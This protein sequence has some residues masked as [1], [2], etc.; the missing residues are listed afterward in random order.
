LQELQ[1]LNNDLQSFMKSKSITGNIN[2]IG[3]LH[4]MIQDYLILRVSGLFDEKSYAIS[5]ERFFKDQQEYEDIKNSEIIK[6][7]RELRGR[8]VAHNHKSAKFPET[9]IILTSNLK[10]QLQN[11]KDLL[12]K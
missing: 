12:P 2:R 1:E 5:F 6:Y 11:L 7:I 8:F 3:N 10:N 4:L 9:S